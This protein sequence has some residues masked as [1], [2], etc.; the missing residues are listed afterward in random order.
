VIILLFFPCLTRYLIR[1]HTDGDSSRRQGED[2]VED[3]D[4]GKDEDKD[5]D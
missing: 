3:G 1:N 5:E 4:E 2:E